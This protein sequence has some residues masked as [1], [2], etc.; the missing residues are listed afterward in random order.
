MN[1]Q[2]SREAVRTAL[3]EIAPEVDFDALKADRPLREQAEID[4]FD[5]INFLLRLQELTGVEIP[6]EDY[7]RIRTLDGLI[8]YLNP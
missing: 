5:F 4:S 2:E 7:D 3:G 8:A 1:P 6:E